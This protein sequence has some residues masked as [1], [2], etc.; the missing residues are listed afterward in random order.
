LEK[1][2]SSSTGLTLPS[3]TSVTRSAFKNIDGLCHDMM[4][5]PC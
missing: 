5:P 1:P 4:E 3:S 2:G